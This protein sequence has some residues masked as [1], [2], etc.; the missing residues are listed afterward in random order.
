[1]LWVFDLDGVVW[2]AGR[3]IEGSADGI[4][5]L[6]E[7]GDRVVFVTNNSNPSV[8]EYVERLRDAGVTMVA[9]EL[10][11]SSQAAASMLDPGSRVTYLG[12]L[13]LREALTERSVE[14]VGPLDGPQSVVVGRALR[15]DF[16]ELSHTA[17]AI[18]SGARFVATNTDATFPT[19]DGLE[20][21]AGALIAYLEV[22]SG[23][24]AE[25][26]GKPN[27]AM[28]ALLQSRF[29]KP[30][31]V[32]GDRP[33]TDGLFAERV[34]A[35]FVLVLSGVTSESDLPVRPE[36]AVV[37]ANLREAVRVITGS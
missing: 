6:R 12:G 16:D 15:L 22:G 1:M 7:R 9:H 10:V 24:R 8:G 35:P 31:Y 19:P 17:G 29:G 21:G 27:A 33:D 26:A 14:L 2:L 3:A 34:G 5:V 18:R 37:A 30:D 32:V 20:P 13:G 11:T 36:P 4:R 25:A 28:A 23:I